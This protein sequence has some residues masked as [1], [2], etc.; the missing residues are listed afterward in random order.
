[1]GNVSRLCTACSKETQT[2]TGEFG[3]WTLNNYYGISGYFCSECYY[4]V[5]H[6]AYGNPNS[7]GEY[8]CMLLKC[9]AK[10]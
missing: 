7:P 4:K 1:M 5:S 6:D 8:V 2:R 9:G 10:K 3:A